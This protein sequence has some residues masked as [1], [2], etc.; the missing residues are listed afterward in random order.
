[1]RGFSGTM[2][3]TES[4]IARYIFLRPSLRRI[5]V[6]FVIEVAMVAPVLAW[7]SYPAL[8]REAIS[9]SPKLPW[10]LTGTGLLAVFFSLVGKLR[11]EK[12]SGMR[13]HFMKVL[14][15]SLIPASQAV[16]VVLIVYIG[17]TWHRVGAWRPPNK[18]LSV[19]G[20]DRC[21]ENPSSCKPNT[22]PRKRSTITPAQCAEDQ[23]R[24]YKCSSNNELASLLVREQSR[25]TTLAQNALNYMNSRVPPGQEGR[26]RVDVHRSLAADIREC[27]IHDLTD[28]REEAIKRIGLMDL[29]EGRCWKHLNH[30]L[31]NYPTA[32]GIWPETVNE[33]SPYL[34]KMEELLRSPK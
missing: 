1:M 27:C 17:I 13:A 32:L 24:P 31:E 7:S 2:H 14:Y 9:S 6:C 34:T 20:P 12:W 30:S 23:S 16:V 26:L 15:E 21:L 4:R 28:L 18:S 33:Y 25:L 8:L 19:A 10:A 22:T 11:R 5:W 29:E 3:I